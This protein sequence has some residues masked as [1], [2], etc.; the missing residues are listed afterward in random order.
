MREHQEKCCRGDIRSTG[1]WS[2][3][4]P[5]ANRV[6]SQYKSVVQVYSQ[7]ISVAV[8]SEFDRS[9]EAYRTLQQAKEH[10]DDTCA[11]SAS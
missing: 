8:R 4:S 10:Q 2:S 11:A 5:C 6:E 9:I 3:M 1:K 7:F